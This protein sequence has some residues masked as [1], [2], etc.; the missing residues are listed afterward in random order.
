MTVHQDQ[1]AIPGS[2]ALVHELWSAGLAFL[3]DRFAAGCARV[4]SGDRVQIWTWYDEPDAHGR[5]DPLEGT[6]VCG[7][8]L[9]PLDPENNSS[10]RL[11]VFRPTKEGPGREVFQVQWDDAECPPSTA[12]GLSVERFERGMWEVAIKRRS[13]WAAEPTEHLQ[14]N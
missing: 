4:Q 12:G 6:E 3:A 7:V 8:L 1:T 2:P 10:W 5:S 11:R 9:Q 13:M 14:C